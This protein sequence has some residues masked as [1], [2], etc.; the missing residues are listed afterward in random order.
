MKFSK[1][2]DFGHKDTIYQLKFGQFKFGESRT[3]YQIRQTFLPPNIPAIQYCGYWKANPWKFL[4][5]QFQNLVFQNWSI[6]K[7][8]P[9]V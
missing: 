6:I 8:E 4:A 7:I 1:W 5:V 2:I 9:V 3:T